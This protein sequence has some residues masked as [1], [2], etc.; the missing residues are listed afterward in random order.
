[1]LYWFLRATEYCTHLTSCQVLLFYFPTG[2]NSFAG[3]ANFREAGASCIRVVIIPRNCVGVN[4]NQR[5]C[6]KIVRLHKTGGDRLYETNNV[7]GRIKNLLSQRKIPVSQMLS[8]LEMGVNALYQF[9]K[10]RVMSCFA[11][12][13]IADYLDCSVDYLLGRTDNP[14]V[15]R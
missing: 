12:A 11:I 10:G 6:V 9:E 1:M 4:G 14:E 7:A 3:F 5:Y 8:D 2:I 13:R 15:N